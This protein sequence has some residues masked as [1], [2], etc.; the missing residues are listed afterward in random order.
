MFHVI[1]EQSPLFGRSVADIE[2]GNFSFVLLVSGF[3]ENAAQDIHARKTYRH[4]EVLHGHRYADIISV[5]DDGRTRVD[6][7]RFHET[8]PE[9]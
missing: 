8:T 5:D 9:P 3:D 2:A 6:Y 4:T 1:D 7:R